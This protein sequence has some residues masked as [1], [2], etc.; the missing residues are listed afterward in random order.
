MK[1]L[2]LL[3]LAVVSALP[4]VGQ[5]ALPG[6]ALPARCYV[7]QRVV[8]PTSTLLGKS[9]KVYLD[10]EA[11]TGNVLRPLNVGQSEV[12]CYSDANKTTLLLSASVS[13]T[14]LPL[15]LEDMAP[16]QAVG[17]TLTLPTLDAA[18]RPLTWQCTPAAG[19]TFTPLGNALTTAQFQAPGP[20]TLSA[21]T[22]AGEEVCSKLF[23]VTLTAVLP[24]KTLYDVD[25]E[26][27]LP[28]T[29]AQGQSVGWSCE[30]GEL[31]SAESGGR[32]Y[33]KAAGK[34]TF[35]ATDEWGFDRGSYTLSAELPVADWTALARPEG[36]QWTVGERVQATRLPELYTVA[37]AGAF[38]PEVSGD[39]YRAFLKPGVVTLSAH[40]RW[41]NSLGSITLD[42]MPR[43]TLDND[44]VDVSK[45]PTNI[46][47][48]R[49]G[50]SLRSQ[51][52]ALPYY[53]AGNAALTWRSSDGTE[54]TVNAPQRKVSYT[55][56]VAG[57]FTLEATT[58]EGVTLASVAIS[59]TAAPLPD[60]PT[61]EPEPEPEP[62]P[63]IVFPTLPT[64]LY[65]GARQGLASTLSNG[66]EVG[67]LTWRV[68]A[69]DAEHTGGAVIVDNQLVVTEPG[70]VKLVAVLNGQREESYEIL[71]RADDANLSK[72]P[73]VYYLGAYASTQYQ[74]A[75]RH[76]LTWL[77]TDER[78]AV[79][80]EN[81]F[82]I[83]GPGRCTLTAY[84][85]WAIEA[86]SKSIEVLLDEVDVSSVP[87]TAT[88][89][90]RVTLPTSGT[91]GAGLTWTVTPFEP[92]ANGTL[93]LTTT[94]AHQLQAYDPLGN[95]LATASVSVEN[96]IVS[97]DDLP[98]ALLVGEV[99]QLPGTLPVGD[100]G[101]L[102]VWWSVTPVEA[103][104][105]TDATGS[106][107]L[108][109]TAPIVELELVASDANGMP[110]A[111]HRLAVM[112]PEIDL[113]FLEHIAPK[114]A[115]ELPGSTA[116]GLSLTWSAAQGTVFNGLLG[117]LAG[118]YTETLYATDRFGNRY[119]PYTF[120]VRSTALVGPR[121]HD[122]LQN[123][124][125]YDLSGR[126]LRNYQGRGLRVIVVQ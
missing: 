44:R 59:C 63:Q 7:G 121:E 123:A 126:R 116:N 40:D 109:A 13:V 61:P 75:A 97:L 103:G 110:A 24:S 34:T 83:V 106:Q 39:R 86:G 71:V 68:S 38:G 29:T 45:I 10:D 111:R 22:E 87:A 99:L 67:R 95:L 36:E 69:A 37:P 100:G 20:V 65:V 112:L 70:K 113:G 107:L 91:H 33:F 89:G 98:A 78:V 49:S 30:D 73:E 31:I 41:D 101:G 27:R 85:P 55:V 54:A 3:P 80:Q 23:V 35:H 105:I 108:T 79:P 28:A 118:P 60:P 74:S 115:V 12:R 53:S 6:F 57:D 56:T 52:F 25:E 84:N 120:D 122:D 47:L 94:G 8:L 14:P 26:L 16:E 58:A 43:P 64:S 125:V 88:L 92:L 76:K 77:S 51:T 9:Y 66:T 72:M 18:S 5:D 82:K 17:A 32:Y 93:Q 48:Q 2:Y 104:T 81:V 46:V 15:N 119:G 50:N 62:E 90:E 1:E 114:S 102:P 124:K 96:S 21:T 11:V 42:V 4:V 117:T 19:A